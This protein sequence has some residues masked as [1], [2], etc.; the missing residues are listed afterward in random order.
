MSYGGYPAIDGFAGFGYG[1]TSPDLRYD[2]ALNRSVYDIRSS[3]PDPRYDPLV[4]QTHL[5]K[6]GLDM[7]LE[8]VQ[9]QMRGLRDLQIDDTKWV[10]TTPVG[11]HVQE[12]MLEH[13]NA[14]QL[15]MLEAERN[16]LHQRNML[17]AEKNRIVTGRLNP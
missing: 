6:P 17:E 2:R 9:L 15:H 5:W 13:H 10:K 7:A 12:A 3:T 16:R 14:A 11:V 1:S 4:V 8:T